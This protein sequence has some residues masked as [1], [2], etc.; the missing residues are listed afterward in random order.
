VVF[1]GSKGPKRW[2]GG[3]VCFNFP[4][5]GGGL[6]LQILFSVLGGV[7]DTWTYPNFLIF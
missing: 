6:S 1:K 2:A 3:R 5:V 4:K 7:V